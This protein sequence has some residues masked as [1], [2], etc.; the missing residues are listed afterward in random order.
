L[1]VFTSVFT[2]VLLRIQILWNMT[3][4]GWLNGSWYSKECSPFIFNAEKG[5][6]HGVWIKVSYTEDCFVSG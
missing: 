2:S 6:E 5:T 3:H 1:E 4:C